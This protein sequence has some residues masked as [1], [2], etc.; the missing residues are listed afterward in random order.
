MF[1]PFRV[2][3]AEVI[4]NCSLSAVKAN[5]D[6]S[7]RCM[8]TNQQDIAYLMTTIFPPCFGSGPPSKTV[9]TIPVSNSTCSNIR[10][11]DKGRQS[12]ALQGICSLGTSLNRIAVSYR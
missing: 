12:R 2:G 4:P 3:L 7:R 9:P 8:E 1:V 6:Q 5:G 10:V 11:I